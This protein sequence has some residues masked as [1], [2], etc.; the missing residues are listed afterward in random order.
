MIKN[1]Y[2]IYDIV[3]ETYGEPINFIN[4]NVAKRT[5][6][7]GCKEME[8]WKNHPEDLQLMKIGEYN[9]E[10]GYFKPENTH[11]TKGEK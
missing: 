2:A 1:Y 6:L 9:T 4:D 3:A 11:I 7:E 10:T 8:Q 5:F